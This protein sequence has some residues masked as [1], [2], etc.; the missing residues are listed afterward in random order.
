MMTEILSSRPLIVPAWIQKG[1]CTFEWATTCL[2]IWRVENYTS[3][4]AGKMMRMSRCVPVL[5]HSTPPS[6]IMLV[7]DVI[8]TQ[9]SHGGF[10]SLWY[11]NGLCSS[12]ER[13]SHAIILARRGFL[14]ELF[15]CLQVGFSNIYIFRVRQISSR[16]RHSPPAKNGTPVSSTGVP[17]PLNHWE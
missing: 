16:F 15:F 5:L 17:K 6:A 13:V 8:V 4:R 12:C 10:S 9:R 14:E 11:S 1:A 2:W 7:V 3:A